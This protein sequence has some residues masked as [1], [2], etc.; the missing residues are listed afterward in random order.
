MF[1]ETGLRAQTETRGAK[2]V[3]HPERS[4]GIQLRNLKGSFNWIPRPGSG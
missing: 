3:G 1:S 2:G 4:R